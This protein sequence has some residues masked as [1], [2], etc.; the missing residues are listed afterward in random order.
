M[1]CHQ[2]RR[3]ELLLSRVHLVKTLD[4]TYFAFFFLRFSY[5]YFYLFVA[6][7]KTISES[8]DLVMPTNSMQKES[9][10]APV[11]GAR[12]AATAA[13][14]AQP[15][16]ESW[17]REFPGSASPGATAS[18]SSM[19]KLESLFFA[20]YYQPNTPFKA[21]AIGELHNRGWRYH[22][23]HKVSWSFFFFLSLVIVWVLDLVLNAHVHI[24]CA[25]VV[26]AH[27]KTQECHQLV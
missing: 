7:R 5:I 23:Q 22:T 21:A 14:A 26:Q 16:P 20:F 8:L 6:G 27:G 15:T 3:L 25:V 24:V 10:A 2:R 17:P 12:G 13:V 4:D 1:Q 9:G 11:S 18:L 19:V